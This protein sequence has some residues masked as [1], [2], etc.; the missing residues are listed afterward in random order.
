MGI[1]FHLMLMVGVWLHVAK[2]NTV[3]VDLP[4]STT[5]APAGWS[6]WNNVDTCGGSSAVFSS[7]TDT[8]L[9]LD[10]SLAPLL[11]AV[12]DPD[13]V[14]LI[15]VSFSL[16]QGSS[17]SDYSISDSELAGGVGTIPSYYYGDWGNG[18]VVIGGEHNRLGLEAMSTV[19]GL[20]PTIS[21]TF[22]ISFTASL[23]CWFT[24]CSI[25]LSC[26]SATVYWID[27]P[28]VAEGELA[29]GAQVVRTD[30]WA[31]PTEP[32]ISSVRSLM[33]LARLA[34]MSRNSQCKCF[35]NLYE[36]TARP[37]GSS[38]QLGKRRGR[39]VRAV[40]VPPGRVRRSNFCTLR[41]AAL[42]QSRF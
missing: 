31:H 5:T 34:E 16:T 17:S 40:Q 41:P 19:T 20:A 3:T 25:S 22:D 35:G 8:S 42:Y 33:Q 38:S 24:T 14:S 2:A 36:T 28:A 23:L 4:Y 26:V 29:V 1:R 27:S 30:V 15:G 39:A 12:P 13:A 21:V 11:A 6:G 37:D 18:V 10:F 9:T 7:E 32:A